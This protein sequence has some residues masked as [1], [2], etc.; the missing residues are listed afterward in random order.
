MGID[1]HGRLPRPDDALDR[2]LPEQVVG[3]DQ[4]E[5][6]LAHHRVFRG[7]QRGP[8]AELPLLGQHR[9]DP[10]A[11]QPGHH[12]P[13]RSG[14]VAHHHQNMLHAGI[15]EHPDG[16]L[17]QLQPPQLNQSLRASPGDRPQTL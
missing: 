4:R 12:R 5:Q 15:H 7:G 1:E 14:V 10:A 17:D 9:M 16:P 8:V 2:S 13:D 11:A 6:V 3:G